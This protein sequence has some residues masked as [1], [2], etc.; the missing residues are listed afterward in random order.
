MRALAEASDHKM[1]L[2]LDA[3][4]SGISFFTVV[5]LR[6]NALLV[7][8]PRSL[9]GNGVPK[10]STVRLTLPNRERRQVRA[11]VVVPHIK[12]PGGMRYALAC[13]VPKA[14]S[15]QCQ[16]GAER[17]TTTRFKNLHLHLED[18][19][20]SFRVVDLSTSG[21][22]IYSGHDS[23]LIGFQPGTDLGTARFRIGERVKI[24]LEHVVA[25]AQSQQTVGLE[26]RVKRDGASERYLMNLLNRLQ[27]NELR[28]LQIETA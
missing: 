3:E 2:R 19:G 17:F 9:R 28:R 23:G 7:A 26:F 15:G 22:R 10:D 1:P 20:R 12:L 25:R 8:K 16:R 14:F 21:A 27:N 13:D 4:H 18:M 6:R 24:E 5:S 11:S